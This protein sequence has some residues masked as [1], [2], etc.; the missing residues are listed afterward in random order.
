MNLHDKIKQQYENGEY[1]QQTNTVTNYSNPDKLG[2]YQRTR[3]SILPVWII[4][5][6]ATFVPAS[7]LMVHRLVWLHYLFLVLLV[8]NTVALVCCYFK[9]RKLK[10]A[11]NQ[12]S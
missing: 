7:Y 9:I 2:W 11:S 1:D 4:L 12:N 3:K 5:L 10:K 8:L 6:I